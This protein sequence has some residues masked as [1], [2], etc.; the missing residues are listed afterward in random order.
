MPTQD[1][2]QLRSI[3]FRKSLAGVSQTSDGLP[4]MG[5][6]GWRDT[7]TRSPALR[8]PGVAWNGE[9]RAR[10][11]RATSSLCEALAEAVTADRPGHRSSLPNPVQH[12]IACIAVARA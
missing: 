9:G 6:S 4:P 12:E 8:S 1:A 7:R 3:Q 2:W 10:P 5:R 11:A